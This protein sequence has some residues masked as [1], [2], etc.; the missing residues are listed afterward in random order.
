MLLWRQ[1]G[2]LVPA[3]Q[4]PVEPEKGLFGGERVQG[5]RSGVTSWPHGRAAV[6]QYAHL[7]ALLFMAPRLRLAAAAAVESRKLAMADEPPCL[8]PSL[9][10]ARARVPMLEMRRIAMSMSRRRWGAGWGGR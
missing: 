2:L 1:R 9:H 5:V 7:V 4:L 8:L 10:P 6:T 3:K